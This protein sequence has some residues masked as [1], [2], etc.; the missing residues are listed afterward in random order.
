MKVKGPWISLPNKHHS[1]PLREILW[2]STATATAT[3]TSGRDELGVNLPARK[4]QYDKAPT[5]VKPARRGM[6]KGLQQMG[7]SQPTLETPLPCPAPPP[8]IPI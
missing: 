5:A 8:T 7:P 6:G 3:A 2:G 4:V 1:G